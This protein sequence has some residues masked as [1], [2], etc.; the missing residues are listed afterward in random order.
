LRQIG[1]EIHCFFDAEAEA[2]EF[3]ADAEGLTRFRIGVGEII[4][5]CSIKLSTPPRLAPIRGM[6]QAS[7]N[8]LAAGLSPSTSKLMTPPK[9]SIMRTATA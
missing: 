7:M 3:V 5:G 9:P 1:D 8:R 4:E 2:H 6:R